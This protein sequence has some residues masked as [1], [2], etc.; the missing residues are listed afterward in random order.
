MTIAPSFSSLKFHPSQQN[1][2]VPRPGA[3]NHSRANFRTGSLVSPKPEGISR[4]KWPKLAFLLK[5][6][7]CLVREAA[8]ERVGGG[9]REEMENY[10][11]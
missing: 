3:L 9:S 10:S 11:G 2:P 8:I 7:S 5:L 6:N 1:T 4:E